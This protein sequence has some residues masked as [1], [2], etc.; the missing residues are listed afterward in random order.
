MEQ[1][2]KDASEQIRGKVRCTGK[3]KLFKSEKAKWSFLQ[4]SLADLRTDLRE[5]KG[6]LMLM[7]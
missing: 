7:L 4:P 5:V 2:A 6:T 1:A 3:I